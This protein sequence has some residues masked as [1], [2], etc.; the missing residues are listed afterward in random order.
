VLD[1]VA[2]SLAHGLVG[3][4]RS[5]VSLVALRRV[6]AWNAGASRQVQWGWPHADEEARDTPVS[7]DISE[8]DRD[9]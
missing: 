2:Q 9:W 6:H 5:T 1:G 4:A 3:T 8:T 7:K